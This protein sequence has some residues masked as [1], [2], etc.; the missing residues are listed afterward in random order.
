MLPKLPSAIWLNE[1]C[2]LNN[3]DLPNIKMIF[4]NVTDNENRSFVYKLFS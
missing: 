1:V 3:R 2:R 4:N